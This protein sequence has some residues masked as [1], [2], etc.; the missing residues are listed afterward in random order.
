MVTGDNY[1]TAKAIAKECGLIEPND[2]KSIVMEGVDFIN[3]IGGVVCKACRTI[4]CDC[5]RDRDTA[6]KENKEMRVDTIF[7]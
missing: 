3:K 6:A 4:A 2:T 1:M 7:N 5:P